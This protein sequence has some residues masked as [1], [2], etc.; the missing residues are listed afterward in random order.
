MKLCEVQLALEEGK[1]IRRSGWISRNT[2]FYK[3]GNYLFAH[4]LDGLDVHS[5]IQSNDYFLEDWEIIEVLVQKNELF[6]CPKCGLQEEMIQDPANKK[7]LGFLN[8]KTGQMREDK[9]K[10][11]EIRHNGTWV[12]NVRCHG[13]EYQKDSNLQH[14][15]KDEW[16]RDI[17]WGTKCNS[18]TVEEIKK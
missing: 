1:R 13:Y 4:G 18:V 12:L 6:L 7:V 9:L 16:G 17:A 15:F 3:K 2:Y 8:L 5:T 10:T 14:N 11:F